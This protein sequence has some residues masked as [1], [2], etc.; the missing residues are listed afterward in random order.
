MRSGWLLCDGDVVCALEIAE[1]FGER[2]KGLRGRTGCEGGLHLDGVTSVHTVGMKFA[3]D[4]AFLTEDLTVVRLARLKPWRLALGR[5]GVR[6]VLQAEAGALERWGVQVG[7][8]MV[9][10]LV[11]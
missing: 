10:R 7:D 3:I 8:Q 5:S 11:A 4:V 1:S 9:I 6:S 2:A